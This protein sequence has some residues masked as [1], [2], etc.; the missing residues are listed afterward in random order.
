[1]HKNVSIGLAIVA[2]AFAA[3]VTAQVRYEVGGAVKSVSMTGDDVKVEIHLLVLD[4]HG[5]RVSG[6]ESMS[7][8]NN[9]KTV[10]VKAYLC[11]TTSKCAFTTMNCTVSPI[12]GVDAY[13]I[14][15]K[16]PVTSTP[17]PG[18]YLVQ[19]ATRIFWIGAREAKRDATG[20]GS[21]VVAQGSTMISAGSN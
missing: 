16:V 10:E 9:D 17:Y 11:S 14:T 5:N 13:L 7:G 19:G 4:E 6:L 15:A 12:D 3:P 21:K 18:I 20:A 1:M 2:F 8:V